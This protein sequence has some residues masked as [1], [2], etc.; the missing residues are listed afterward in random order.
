MV[1]AFFLGSLTFFAFQK[2]TSK[3]G[4]ALSI[5]APIVV[6]LLCCGWRG[7]WRGNSNENE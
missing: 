7:L 3:H 5:I 6:V 1:G 4:C 2:S